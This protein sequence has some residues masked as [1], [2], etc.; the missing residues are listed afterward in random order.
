MKKSRRPKRR[1]MSK[2]GLETYRTLSAQIVASQFWKREPL[3]GPQLPTQSTCHP[4]A[5]F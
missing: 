1:K 5:L 2:K 4:E 3:I